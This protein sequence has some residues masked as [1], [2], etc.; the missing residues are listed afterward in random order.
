MAREAVDKRGGLTSYLRLPPRQLLKV[1]IYGLLL[2]NFTVYLGN[3]WT[4]A[5][6][7]AR[8]DWTF[9]DWARA[10]A[11]TL[12]EAAWFV[13]LFLFELETYLLSDEAFTRARVLLLHGLR[14]VCYLFI[15]HT[16]YAFADYALALAE[17]PVAGTELCAFAEREVAWAFNLAYTPL[18]AANCRNLSD[19]SAFFLI[20]QDTLVT[21]AAGLAIE[22]QLAVIDVIEV[23]AWLLILFFIELAVRL[24]DRGI[25]Q[26]TLFRAARI[27]KA[28]LYT[29]LWLCAAYWLYR[30]HWV[31]AWDEALWILGF[32]AIDGNLEE[33]REEIEETPAGA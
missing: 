22:R 33:W 23:V 4:V 17:V 21:D 28:G 8:P 2:V 25:T 15:A 5:R 26:G 13:L 24:Q 14:L 31:F 18:D 6:H 1:V 3:D 30:G 7:T 29:V 19:A 20:E 9:L 32:I 11:T 12:D 27:G 10:F 16:V